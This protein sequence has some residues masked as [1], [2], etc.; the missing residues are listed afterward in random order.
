MPLKVLERPT[1]EK[2][3]V[4]CRQLEVPPSFP[5]KPLGC[6]GDAGAL[7]TDDDELAEKFRWIR[8]HGQE[9]KHHVIPSLA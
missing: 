7:F 4:T 3:P 5:S 1:K 8:V 9:R 2:N 6:Y